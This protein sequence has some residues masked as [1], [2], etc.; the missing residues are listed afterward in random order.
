MEH[1]LNRILG[2]HTSNQRKILDPSTNDR[3]LTLRVFRTEGI[4][5]HNT[6][7]QRDDF[8]APVSEHPD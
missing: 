2:N 5:G 4:E 7:Y 8:G 1:H 3:D 6:R